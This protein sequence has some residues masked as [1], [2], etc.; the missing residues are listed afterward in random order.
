MPEFSPAQITAES[1]V[2]VQPAISPDGKM[3]AYIRNESGHRELRVMDVGSLQWRR[4]TA[5]STLDEDPCWFPDGEALA[6]AS[7]HG[8]GFSI[9]KIGLNGGPPS[10]PVLRDARDP[11]VSPDGKNIA[12]SRRGSRGFS[13][14]ALAL[15]ADTSRQ[16]VLTGD[17]DGAW[18][19]EDPAWSPDGKRICYSTRHNL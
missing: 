19:H 17:D 3:I 18:H 4:L 2:N 12:F 5:G 6:Y 8:G 14:V 11:A 13:R 9:W 15:L 1:A 16:K 10:L 7:D